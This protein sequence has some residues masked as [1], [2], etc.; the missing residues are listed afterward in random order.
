MYNRCL[1]SFINIALLLFT[2]TYASFEYYDNYSCKYCKDDICVP[3]NNH[4]DIGT[5]IIP[6]KEGVNVTY[7]SDTCSSKDIDLNLCSFKNCTS[8]S[9]CLSNKCLKGHCSFNEA[10]P[11]VQC[12]YVRTVHSN[13][14]LGDPKGY[15]THCG[16]F[17]GDKC[18]SNKDCG[19][20]NCDKYG[21]RGGI[22]EQPNNDSGC[23]SF[24]DFGKSITFYT[25]IPIY[26]IIL[27]CCG[28]CYQYKKFRKH[29][30][31]IST[32]VVILSGMPW[33]VILS[34]DMYGIIKEDG[35]IL[36]Y[37][38]KIIIILLIIYAIIW[39]IFRVYKYKEDPD[40]DDKKLQTIESL[41]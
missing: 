5:V 8:D 9:E 29:F 23:H 25:I 41:K 28:G 7:I 10:N 15:K 31:C 35:Y 33:I 13:P 24:C 30:K 36:E 2:T 6:N 4:I 20:F 19:S 1:F 12:F 40:S 3:C 16:L 34:Y 38:I 17:V 18:D 26:V 32:I 14:I 11:I 21:R 39:Y 37:I 22:C 27:C